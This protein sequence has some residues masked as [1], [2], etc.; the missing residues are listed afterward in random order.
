[1]LETIA[2]LYA[3]LCVTYGVYHDRSSGDVRTIFA[4]AHLE[5]KR[6]KSKFSFCFFFLLHE[7]VF[8]DAVLKANSYI[9]FSS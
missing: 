9:Q 4:C 1:M 5:H 6:E 2:M 7:I 3:L 8:N